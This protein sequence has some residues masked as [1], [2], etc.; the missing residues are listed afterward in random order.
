VSDEMFHRPARKRNPAQP[1]I[2]EHVG[3]HHRSAVLNSI[4]IHGRGEKRQLTGRFS[5]GYAPE[6][7]SLHSI[8]AFRSLFAHYLIYF[9]HEGCYYAWFELPKTDDNPVLWWFDEMLLTETD[10]FDPPLN[11][12]IQMGEPFIDTVLREM[13]HIAELLPRTAAID[14]AFRKAA[15]TGNA[16]KVDDW[17]TIQ[18][19]PP[20]TTKDEE[21][22]AN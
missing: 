22:E 18:K 20:Q 7:I 19:A 21:G 2:G 1:K 16:V 15:E 11:P 3:E 5:E 13:Q 9:S 10:L 6:D 14:E 17:L 12:E 4:D 8:S